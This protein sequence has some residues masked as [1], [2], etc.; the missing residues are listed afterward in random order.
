MKETGVLILGGG[1][2]GLALGCELSHRLIPFLLLEGGP[3]LGNSFRQMAANTTYG[4]WINNLLP[5][6]QVPMF[7]LLKRTRRE[8]YAEY[9]SD[10]A[11]AHQLSFLTGVSVTKVTRSGPSFTVETNQGPFQAPLVVNATGYFSNPFQ[12]DFPGADTSRIRQIHA[13]QFREAATVRELIGQNRARV[14]IVGKRLTA[15]ETMQRLVKAGYEVAL[16]ARSKIEFGPSQLLEACVSPFTFVVEEMLARLP[17]SPLPPN[18]DV[19]MSGGLQR[20]LV[21]SGR[22]PVFPE[23]ERFNEDSIVFR[24]GLERRF[25][26]VIYA[27]GYRPALA[28]LNELVAMDPKTGYPPLLGFESKQVR[29]LYFLGLI[30]LRTFRSQF[31]RGIREDAGV[32]AEVLAQRLLDVCASQRVG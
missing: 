15:G 2:A 24:D 29:D 31:L 26:L 22:V 9:L 5:H 6:S 4:P 12:V 18:L 7:D 20:Q 11:I 25:D 13:G 10:Y 14:L 16:S 19:K 23:I 27:T 21:E 8:E 32:L 3:N 30:G 28:H 17:G 1:P